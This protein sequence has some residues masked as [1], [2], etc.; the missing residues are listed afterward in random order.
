MTQHHKALAALS[1]GLGLIGLA[2][3]GLA[4]AACTVPTPAAPAHTPSGLI[5]AVYH[6]ETAVFSDFLRASDEEASIVGLWKFEML[7]KSTATHKNPMPD[8]VL[9]DFGTVAWHSDHTELMNS[10][11]RNPA[12]GDFCQGAWHRVAE[13]TFA[14]NHIALAYTNGTYTG[15]TH[16]HERVTVDSTGNHYMGTFTL[17][18]YLA[19]VTPGHE[20]DETTPLV[21]ITGTIT[22]TRV[23][24]N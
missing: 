7:A 13:N 2:G 9:I 18:A 22:A 20:F 12:D 14:L 19:S 15:P 16:F 8:G 21:T 11:S 5:P 6:P 24:A 17:T 3:A 10:G 23:P 1:A 4:Q